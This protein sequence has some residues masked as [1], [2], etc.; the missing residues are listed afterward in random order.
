MENQKWLTTDY[1][2][3][4]KCKC[5]ACRHSCCHGWQIPITRKEYEQLISLECNEEMRHRLDVSFITP[6]YIDENRY[7]ILSF[8]YSGDCHLQKDGLC[9][10]HKEKGE[11]SLPRVC[12]LYPRSLKKINDKNTAVCSSSCEAVVEMLLKDSYMQLKYEELN[13]HSE[14]EYKVDNEVIE[15]LNKCE[16]I[17][18][19]AKS[20]ALGIQEICLRENETEFIKDYNQ[21]INPLNEGLYILN[22]LVNDDF[23]KEILDEINIRYENN[24]FQ[25]EK[26]KID[27]ENRYPKWNIY[28]TNVINNSLLFENFPFVDQR[29]D[30]TLAYKGLCAS[31]GLLRI[32]TIG[33]TATHQNRD[34]L[35]DCVAALFHLI[36]H[37]SFYYNVN[38]LAKSAALLLKL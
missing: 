10:I 14:I 9:L 19:N 37:T 5:S 3:D 17:T 28:F 12:R 8:N 31:Y 24:Y 36:D 35:I 1:Y 29:F 26:D 32:I 21:D 15:E 38:V 25:Y 18:R 2:K 6:D 16:E 13:E 30:K 7:R 20:L 23:L 27:F 34:D 11:T 33:Y 4:F 22:R